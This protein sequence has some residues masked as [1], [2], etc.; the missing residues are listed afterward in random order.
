MRKGRY[1]G[2]LHK[3]KYARADTMAVQ[4]TADGEVGSKQ[5]ILFQ[6]QDVGSGW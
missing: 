6:N 3:D 1:K 4:G 5:L 2:S